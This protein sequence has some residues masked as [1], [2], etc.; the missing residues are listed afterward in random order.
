MSRP[1]I[2]SDQKVG[3]PEEFKQIGN[4]SFSAKVDDTGVFGKNSRENIGVHSRI[5][6]VAIFLQGKIRKVSPKI[7]GSMLCSPGGFGS[8]YK[9]FFQRVAICQKIINFCNR[10]G[11]HPG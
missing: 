6:Y 8:D 3:M 11:R 9:R 5:N 7:I 10:F 4:G 1:G 2:G